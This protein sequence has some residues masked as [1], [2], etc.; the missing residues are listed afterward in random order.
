MRVSGRLLSTVSA[1][2]IVCLNPAATHPARADIAKAG[3]AAVVKGPSVTGLVGAET[4]V[5]IV[6][7]DIFADEVVNTDGASATELMF[8]DQTNLTITPGSSVKIDKFVFDPNGKKGAVVFN[9]AR[10]SLRFVTGSQDPTEYQ[11]KT[12]VAT[13]GVRGTIVNFITTA[14]GLAVQLED[15]SAA[16]IGDNGKLTP[17]TPATQLAVFGKNGVVATATSGN[18]TAAVTALLSS[19]TN[20]ATTAAALLVVAGNAKG[21][22][23]DAAARAV[24]SSIAGSGIS[25]KAITA[26]IAIAITTA[27]DPAAAAADIASSAASLPDDL[28]AAVGSGFASA[29][30]SLAQIDPDASNRIKFIQGQSSNPALAGASPPGTVTPPQAPQPPLPPV[31]PPSVSPK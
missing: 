21:A 8:L 18:L 24:A 2:T 22:T 26:A 13:I 15:G 3:A 27:I 19:S 6:G 1:I 12:P 23:A 11:I 16:V 28:A 4:N 14:D 20:K 9:V 7:K 10:G 25:P 5:I 31:P 29:A 17:M 30:A